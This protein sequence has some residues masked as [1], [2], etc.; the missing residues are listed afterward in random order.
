MF[1]PNVPGAM[2]IQGAMFVPDSRVLT[3]VQEP[4]CQKMQWKINQHFSYR[5]LPHIF[6]VKKK[7]SRVRQKLKSKSQSSTLIFVKP[8]MVWIYK[9]IR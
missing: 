6:Q 2:F 7:K 4:L 9:K 8:Q 5:G 1:L 3:A